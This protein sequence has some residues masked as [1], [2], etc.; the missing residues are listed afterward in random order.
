M[1]IIL[2][3][4]LAGSVLFMVGCGDTADE[5]KPVETE[6]GPCVG[7]KCAISDKPVAK[8]Q[9]PFNPIPS[10]EQLMPVTAK[11]AAVASNDRAL[12]GQ[13]GHYNEV[14]LPGMA[15]QEAPQEQTFLVRTFKSN[16]W[17]GGVEL[18]AEIDPDMMQ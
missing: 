6:C 17:P 12:T 4:I 16:L 8:A 18:G 1:K 7:G 10:V 3:A 9:M 15:H 5:I 13:P 14:K 11:K 2:A